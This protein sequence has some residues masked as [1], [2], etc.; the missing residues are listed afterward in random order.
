MS[1]QAQEALKTKHAIQRLKAVTKRAQTSTPQ[2]P[3]AHAHPGSEPVQPHVGWMAIVT[4]GSAKKCDPSV[5]SP[6]LAQPAQQESF[7]CGRCFLRAAVPR[8][9][10]EKAIC[11]TAP[12]LG[13]GNP[14]IYD[15]AEW[16][17]EPG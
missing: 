15:L 7:E 4:G 12:Q 9:F 3:F 6:N 11:I 16:K 10:V 5:G 13:K 8:N 14:A 17:T 1:P 2:C